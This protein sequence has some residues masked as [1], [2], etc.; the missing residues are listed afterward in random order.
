MKIFVFNKIK[1]GPLRKALLK[2]RRIWDSNPGDTRMPDGFQDRSDQPLRQ[3]SEKLL[4]YNTSKKYYVKNFFKN[5]LADGEFSALTTLSVISTPP[6]KTTV[7]STTVSILFDI[8]T[9]LI[10]FLIAVSISASFF[11]FNLK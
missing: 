10:A 9:C 3:S 4:Y 7:F 6:K 8:A 1:K 11:S 2:W 5:Y